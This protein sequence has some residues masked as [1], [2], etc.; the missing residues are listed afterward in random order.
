MGRSKKNR[1]KRKKNGYYD[2]NSSDISNIKKHKKSRFDDSRR[3][4]EVQQKMFVDWD[5]L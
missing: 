1:D 3:D 5:T 2:D 4:K